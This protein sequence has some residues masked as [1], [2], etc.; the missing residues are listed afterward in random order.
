M[1][2]ETFSCPECSVKLRRSAHLKPGALVRGGF[3]FGASIN[4]PLAVIGTIDPS[5]AEEFIGFRCAR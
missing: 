2:L 3:Y 1:A 4:G 5:R